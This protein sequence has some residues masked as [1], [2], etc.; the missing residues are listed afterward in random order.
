MELQS[1]I[2]KADNPNAE[3]LGISSPIARARTRAKTRAARADAVR[4]CP[5]HLNSNRRSTTCPS[6][7]ARS[8][9]R[10][11]WTANCRE[12]LNCGGRRGEFLGG[13]KRGSD[14]LRSD[15]IERIGFDVG[16]VRQGCRNDTRCEIRSDLVGS[17]RAEE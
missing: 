6:R 3:G 11:T 10:R 13:L 8:Q 14:G 2:A 15:V 4:P 17:R 9:V 5:P 16:R 12:R 1:G 7:R